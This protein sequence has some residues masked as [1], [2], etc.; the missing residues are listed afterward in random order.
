L[1][2]GRALARRHTLL[3]LPVVALLGAIILSAA[4]RMQLYVHYYGLTVDRVDTLVFMGWLGVV[5]VLLTTTV[6]RDRGRPFAPWSVISGLTT[7]AALHVL[8]PD[9]VVA[10]ANIAR[11]VP[12]SAAADAELDVRHLAT[13]SAD[14]VELVTA[15]TLAAP[16]QVTGPAAKVA[17]ESRCVAVHQLLSRW[18]PSSGARERKE[19]VD[20]WQSW[21]AAERN[22]LRV[23]GAHAAELRRLQH[24]TCTSGSGTRTPGYR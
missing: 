16:V 19:S 5:L 23:V 15:A 20:S 8:V 3:S 11:A 18:G 12:A 24:A 22:A 7:L 6:L 9:V 13:L 1:Q 4:A 21:N 10:R 2:P 17:S 14:A